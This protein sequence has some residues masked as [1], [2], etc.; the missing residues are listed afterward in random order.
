MGPILPG[1]RARSPGHESQSNVISITILER[2]RNTAPKRQRHESF[3]LAKRSSDEKGTRRSRLNNFSFR[4]SARDQRFSVQTGLLSLQNCPL[5]GGGINLGTGSCPEQRKLFQVQGGPLR[6][7]LRLVS[8][9]G[10]RGEQ[11]SGRSVRA[12]A[13]ASANCANRAASAL[14]FQPGTIAQ[15]HQQRRLAVQLRQ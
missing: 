4:N 14:S 7:R 6:P 1:R 15:R 12:G 11:V 5:L 10:I 9:A 13:R 3:L 8:A 2:F